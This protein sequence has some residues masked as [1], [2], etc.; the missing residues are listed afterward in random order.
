[1]SVTYKANTALHPKVILAIAVK[2]AQG[3]MIGT[4]FLPERP[5]SH[6]VFEYREFGQQDREIGAMSP[7]VEEGETTPLDQTSYEVKTGRCKE[8]REGT[9]LTEQS[10]KFLFRDTLRDHVVRISDKIAVRQ[11]NT[12]FT[13]LTNTSLS[14]I[15]TR[16]IA[17]GSEWDL[18]N[19]AP[20]ND[21]ADSKKQI[22]DSGHV[23][24]DTLIIGTDGENVLLKHTRLL[25][26]TNAG[27]I[28][29]RI[30]REGA[31][32]H[33]RGYDIFVSDVVKLLDNKNPNSKLIPILQDKAIVL[34]RGRDLGFTA[35]AEPFTARR[36]PIPDRRAIMIQ[37]FKTFTAKII[38]PRW[39]EI[40]QNIHST[41][42][43]NT[44]LSIS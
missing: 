20:L 1:M 13:E 28:N 25:Y 12:I 19:G 35:V 8:V 21:M 31:I 11:E 2:R 14:G 7:Y 6:P 22:R 24:P 40:I 32:G 42:T 38:R 4:K 29:Q 15:N 3:Q 37:L 39:I 33:V 26:W 43:P 30:M 44:V 18:A 36:I 9:L 17:G 16:L 41:L 10:Q 23:L 5:V 34:K 27:P